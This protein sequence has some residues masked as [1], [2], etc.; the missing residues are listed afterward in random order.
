MMRQRGGTFFISMIETPNLK[1]QLRQQ[2][3]LQRKQLSLSERE[4]YSQQ[5]MDFLFAHLASHFPANAQVQLLVYHALPFEV[6]TSALF[7]Q[8][9]YQI[10][11]PRMLPDM[12][13]AWV[14]VTS[15]TQWLHMDFGV[16]EPEQ[17]ELWQKEQHKT[18]LIAPLLG[19]DRAGNRLGMGKGY[20]DRWLVLHAQALDL[21][22]GL[23]YSCQELSKVPVE[24]HDAPLSTIITE[25]GV[26]ACPT[27]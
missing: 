6:D 21:Q 4:N 11:A 2:L 25:H 8:E 5:I 18:V 12:G 14:K 27:T 19:F 17:G 22:V 7:T 10:F 23:A 26:I 13:M 20:F 24:P 9:K 1:H 15:D 16:Q 3:T